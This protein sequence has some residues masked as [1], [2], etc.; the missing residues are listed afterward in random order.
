MND[1]I[2]GVTKKSNKIVDYLSELLDNEKIMFSYEEDENNVN[3]IV[4]TDN[5]WAENAIADIFVG[6]YKYKQISKFLKPKFDNDYL[7]S[8]FVGAIISIDIE[9]E[10]Q[11]ILES[12][13]NCKWINL[14]GIYNFCLN[15]IR[16]SWEALAYLSNRL[17]SQCNTEKDLYKLTMFMLGVED[18]NFAVLSVEKQDDIILLKN[19]ERLSLFN[20][21]EKQECNAI[22]T[23]LANCPSE[24]IVKSNEAFTKEFMSVLQKIGV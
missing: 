15:K 24:I 16:K 3:F 7:F 22:A 11:Q 19:G 10:R 21:F 12:L 23:I 17:Y 4:N 20:F 14:D 8:A 18:D 9:V 1:K 13:P 2:I 6:H 5:E